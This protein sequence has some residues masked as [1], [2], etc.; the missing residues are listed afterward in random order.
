ME[1]FR[2]T[3]RC[4]IGLDASLTQ[5]LFRE[6]SSVWVE[7]EKSLLVSEWVLLLDTSSLGLGLALGL[8]ENGLDFRGV[9]KAGDIGVGDNVGGEEE[10]FLEGGG[11]G[12]SAIDLIKSAESSR[13]PDNETSK[14]TAWGELKKVERENGGG[15]NTRNVAES[16]NKLLAINLWVVDDEGSTALAVS[17]A[18]QLTLTSTDFAG[19]LDLDEVSASTDGL[20]KGNGSLGLGESVTL[21]G[22]GVDNK[23]NLRDVLN[24]MATS[25][26]KGW[27]GRGSEGRGSSK[28]SLA[29]IDLLMPLA[30][31]LGWSKH[32]SGSTHV[33]ESSLTSTVSTTT[34]D[35]GNT[36]NSTT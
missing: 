1:V 20:E 24:T 12:G 23:W 2:S 4:L 11:G 10:V 16:S 9:D 21:E 36:C 32:S 15:L 14:V 26:E 28:S 22:L 3:L 29:N 25:E 7:S 30:P 19:L 33:T 17:A 18:S 35:T 34:R 5:L 8:S 31:D 13:G 27:D 6:S